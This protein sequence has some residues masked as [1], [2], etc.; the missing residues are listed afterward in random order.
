MSKAKA[1]SGT[2]KG[3]GTGTGKKGWNR[4]KTSANK[5]K[6]AKPYVS[7]GVK[8]SSDSKTSGHST[9]DKTEK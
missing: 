6:S 2:G 1:K 7:K 5:K 3:T 8:H 4:W 9:G